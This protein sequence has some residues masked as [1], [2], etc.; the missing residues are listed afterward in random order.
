MYTN[1]DNIHALETDY[2]YIEE[3]QLTN[4][5]KGLFTAIPI[6]KD[7]IIAYFDGEIL[8]KEEV[9]FRIKNKQDQYFINQLDGSILDSLHSNCFA[10]YANDATGFMT[11]NYK[12]NAQISLDEKEKICLIATKKIKVGEEIFCSYGKKYWSKYKN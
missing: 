9:N 8:T 5:G 6:Y 3:S 12:N 2:L 1:E 10:K 11:S 7:E 4:A